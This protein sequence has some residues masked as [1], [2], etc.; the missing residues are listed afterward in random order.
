MKNITR[1]NTEGMVKELKRKY[2]K[3]PDMFDAV[4]MLGQLFPFSHITTRIIAYE[5]VFTKQL[6]Q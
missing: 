4:C 6:K 3:K 5:T 1:E 2:K